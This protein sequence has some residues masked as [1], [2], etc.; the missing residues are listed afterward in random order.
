[1]EN[2]HENLGGQV[3][4]AGL[5]HRQSNAG[6]AT[7]PRLIW[8]RWPSV[9]GLLAL[10]AN[11]SDG[12]DAHLAALVIV[13]AAMCYLGAA[14]L[15]FARA[16]WL[17]VGLSIVVVFAAALAGV[18]KTVAGLALG[19][20]VGLYG[21]VRAPGGR[22]GE[23]ALQGVAFLGFSA[24]ALSAMLSQPVLAAYLAAAAALSH[25]VWDVIHFVRNKVV[26]RSLT[27]FCFVLDLGLGVALLLAAW[28]LFPA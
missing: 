21:L 5:G 2:R 20:G 28:G 17:M 13:L 8:A 15:G 18:D 27:E 6:L 12:P 10:L 1:M 22:R 25:C 11:I 4:P 9:V 19:I 3:A 7:L 26:E 16:G 23:V 14:A 24:L